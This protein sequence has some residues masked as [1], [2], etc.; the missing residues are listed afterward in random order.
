M[1][2]LLAVMYNPIGCRVRSSCVVINKVADY[3]PEINPFP[4]TWLSTRH[5]VNSGSGSSESVKQA[6]RIGVGE[7][8]SAGVKV[9]RSLD[10]LVLLPLMEFRSRILSDNTR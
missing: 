9:I 10:V 3:F 8:A 1:G 6:L 5:I 2:A 4:E 7:N